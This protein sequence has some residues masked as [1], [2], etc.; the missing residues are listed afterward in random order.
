[1]M[2]VARL[3]DLVGDEVFRGLGGTPLLVPGLA[4]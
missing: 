4:R 3:C 1:M 2:Q